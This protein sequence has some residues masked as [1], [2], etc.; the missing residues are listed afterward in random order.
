MNRYNTWR[1]HRAN[2]QLSPVEYERQHELQS[3]NLTLTA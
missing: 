2:G 1:R 3:G